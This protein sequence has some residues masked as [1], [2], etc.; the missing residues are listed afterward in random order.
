MYLK[1][2]KIIY[3]YIL[4]LY[5]VGGTCCVLKNSASST[6]HL[7]VKI[8]NCYIYIT[9]YVSHVAPIRNRLC[10]R[11]GGVEGL[12]QS[13]PPSKTHSTTTERNI[14]ESSIELSLLQ[15]SDT[16]SWTL[17]DRYVYRQTLGS[18]ALV[19]LLH[20]QVCVYLD[21]VELHNY[22]YLCIA[23]AMSNQTCMS[24][25]MTVACRRSNPHPT[26]WGT[27][28]LDNSLQLPTMWNPILNPP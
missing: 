1:L 22:S 19:G 13:G 5:C 28:N 20:L 12:Q 8:C 24:E 2:Y 15:S 18:K 6:A 9:I 7:C 3:I 26:E 27:M 14:T 4:I 10:T 11:G 16:E 17:F 23:A 21:G 25:A